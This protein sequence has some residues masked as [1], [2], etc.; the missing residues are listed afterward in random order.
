MMPNHTE[1]QKLVNFYVIAA[2]LAVNF[3]GAHATKQWREG[4]ARFDVACIVSWLAVF[5]RHQ[6]QASH[7]SHP[8]EM[9]TDSF[10]SA[11]EGWRA[12]KR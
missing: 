4:V 10:E 5:S 8:S 1:I 9:G 3:F 7:T 2:P 12:R 6:H 11:A